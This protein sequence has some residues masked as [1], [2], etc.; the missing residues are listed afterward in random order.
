MT[1]SQAR[2][3]V[4]TVRVA[5]DLTFRDIDP[6]LTLVSAAGNNVDGGDTRSVSLPAGTRPGFLVALSDL[7][8][9][10]VDG[11]GRLCAA[12]EPARAP[13]QYVY[14]GTFYDLTMKSSEL[15]R[16]AT[17][18]GQRYT[19]VARSDFE[20]RNRRNGDK[21]RFQLTYGT[22]GALAGIPVHAV[23]QPRWWFQVQLFLDDGT[24]F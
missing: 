13:I 2:A 20:M 16:A 12:F 6:L 23:Y 8:T 17:I 10:S 19:D 18:D 11:Y 21:T 22:T 9:T 5:R 1:G 4:T 24:E 7:V 14:F 3:G 15:L